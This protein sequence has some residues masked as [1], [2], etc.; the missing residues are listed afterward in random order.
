[1][2]VVE[3]RARRRSATTCQ[4][5]WLNSG[6]REVSARPPMPGLCIFIWQQR[7]CPQ[8]CGRAQTEASLPACFYAPNLAVIDYHCRWLD[9][10]LS[11]VMHIVQVPSC[12]SWCP[13]V[14]HWCLSRALFAACG[15]GRRLIAQKVGENVR[16]S[17]T[18]RLPLEL[19]KGKPLKMEMPAAKL[20]ECSRRSLVMFLAL[21]R[22][23]HLLWPFGQTTI[24]RLPKS[25]PFLLNTGGGRGQRR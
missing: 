22:D 20:A 2:C 11:Q 24:S 6:R 7:R 1:M 9:R 25:D 23:T 10:L 18:G 13:G 15:V 12:T 8:E 21:T 14:L 3:V 16:A 4:T 19:Q 17:T 5:I